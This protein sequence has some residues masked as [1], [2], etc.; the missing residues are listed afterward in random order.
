VYYTPQYIV[1]YI[2]KNTVGKLLEDMTPVEASA[3]K[4][5]DPA[6]GSG[7]FLLGAYQYLLNWHKDF[8]NLNEKQNRGRKDNPLTPSG[9]LTTAAKKR[10]LT[11]SIYGVDLDANAVEVTKLSLLLKCLEGETKESIE[12][13]SQLFH[14]RILP[15]LDG[16]IKSGNSLIDLDYYG[17][18]MDFSEERKIKPF[19]W[20]KAFPEVFKQGGFDCVIGNPPYLKER[21]SKEIFEPILS[22]SLGKIYHQGKMDF[23]H[24]FLHKGIDI[25][26]PD[27]F[28]SFITNSYWMKSAG[29][30]KMISRINNE[31]TVYEI[32]NFD[33]YKVFADVSGKHNI[34]FFIKGKYP[35]R[36]CKIRTINKENPTTEIEKYKVLEIQNSILIKNN[37]L[38]IQSDTDLFE[39]CELLGV[40]FEV[41]QG[42]VE[43]TDK[44]TKKLKENSKNRNI[45]IGDGVFVLTKEEVNKLGFNNDEMKLL[46]PYVNTNHVNRYSLKFNN[47]YLLYLG[48][49]ERE[50]V[51]KKKYPNIKKHLDSVKEFIT[52]SNAP[53]G[54]NRPR[55]ARFF[56]EP[57]LICKGMFDKPA[58]YY[59][60][61]KYYC[62]FSFSVIIQKSNKYELKLLLALMNSKL[63]EYW[64]NSAGKKRGIGVDIGVQVFREFPLPLIDEPKNNITK[65]SSNT[66]TSFYN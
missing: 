36:L 9:E 48:K 24:Y 35:E 37:K 14:D 56:D 20:Q 6:C 10:I 63:G 3:V 54:I 15:D 7:S 26:K 31:M 58:F 51:A 17:N 18:E 57:K 38:N 46:K 43:A 5:V 25:L 21:G 19:S 41:S 47:E 33:D 39:N 59:D 8:Y 12:A 52:S 50:Y 16:N 13:Q 30:S 40:H 23:W 42:V 27:S 2:V 53:Y 64:F 4:I 34:S 28:L 29:A 61:E 65:K 1:D 11:N 55:E 60:E 44:I 45:N 62:G 32:V 49:I 22:S 66:L